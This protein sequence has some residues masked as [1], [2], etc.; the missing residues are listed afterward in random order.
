MAIIVINITPVPKHLPHNEGLS[1]LSYSCFQNPNKVQL[2][3]INKLPYFFLPRGLV[4]P[5]DVPA[6]RFDHCKRDLLSL[7]CSKP[8]ILF[9]SEPFF[10]SF[11]FLMF[12]I[13]LHLVSTTSITQLSSICL[14]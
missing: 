1:N 4:E 5:S 7:R 11:F 10:L 12:S 6:C 9:F 3:I 2:I 14:P 8:V 13:V